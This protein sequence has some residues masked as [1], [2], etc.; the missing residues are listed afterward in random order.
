MRRLLVPGALIAIA[1]LVGCAQLAAAPSSSPVASVDASTTPSPSPTPDATAAPSSA[2]TDG[3]QEVATTDGLFRWR[4]PADWTARDASF[5]AEDGLGHVNHVTIVSDLEQELAVFGSAFYGDRGGACDDWDGDGTF[6]VPASI[7]LE[8]TVPLGDGLI[9]FD[10][11]P[12]AE[13]RIVAFTSRPTAEDAWFI[14]GYSLDPFEG[15][16]VPC[17]PYNDVPVPEGYP[18][19]SF[20]TTRDESLWR[21]DSLEQGQAYA[22]TEEYEELMDMFRSLEIVGVTP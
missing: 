2:P 17:I 13:G 8:E 10:G 6:F 16:Q 19:A 1:G 3:W 22:Q 14:A 7:H 4:I 15:G 11:E 21:V 12:E 5:E 20:G 18:D 9:G